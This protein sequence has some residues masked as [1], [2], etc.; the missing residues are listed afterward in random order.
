MQQSCRL[1]RLYEHACARASNKSAYCEL[2][3]C[4]QGRG[5]N[6]ESE[7]GEDDAACMGRGIPVLGWERVVCACAEGRRQEVGAEKD[8][9]AVALHL[10]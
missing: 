10:E 4:A 7:P 1:G 8:G 3:Q 5:P 6:H 2:P 9:W